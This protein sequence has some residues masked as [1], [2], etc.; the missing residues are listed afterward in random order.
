MIAPGTRARWPKNQAR[1]HSHLHVRF[2][3]SGLFFA[4]RGSI[5][6]LHAFGFCRHDYSRN[7]RRL[8]HFIG[9]LF[10]MESNDQALP[11]NSEREHDGLRRPGLGRLRR[12][13]ASA[14]RGHAATA[15]CARLHCPRRGSRLDASGRPAGR[16]GQQRFAVLISAAPPGAAS[17]RS[18]NALYALKAGRIRLRAPP[19]RVSSGFVDLQSVH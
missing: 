16:H 19:S 18:G 3:R 14:G 9:P 12:G 1:N 13:H 17:A 10:R 7:C 2:G 5:Y 15:W 6:V 4:Y 11:T 8:L